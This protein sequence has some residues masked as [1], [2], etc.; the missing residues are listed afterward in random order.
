MRASLADEARRGG[1]LLEA[2]PVAGGV[3]DPGVIVGALH[4]GVQ[5]QCLPGQL[6]CGQRARVGKRAEWLTLKSI[7]EEC[8][9]DC[10]SDWC[11]LP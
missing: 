8:Q 4:A 7:Q 2:E 11:D 5:S 6:P 1:N 3:E 9:C 10:F